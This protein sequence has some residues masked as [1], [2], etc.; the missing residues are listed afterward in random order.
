MFGF[1]KRKGGGGN[2][3]DP[4]SDLKTVSRW[5]ENLPAGDIY[6][7][8]EQVVQN[9]IQFN[10]AGLA[11]S[12]DRLQVLMHLDE[13]ARDMQYT[14]CQQYL[15]NPRMSKVIE[16]RLWTAIHAFYWEITRGYHAFLMDF[17]ANPGG[18]RIQQH[19]P[20]IAARALRG[21][22]DIFKWRYFRYERAEEK[23]WLR[24]HNIYRISEFDSFQNNRFKLYAQESTPSSC[25]EEYVRALLLSPLGSGSLTPR[26]IEMVDRWLSNWSTLTTL[27][28]SYNPEHHF[29]IVDTTHGQG[30]RRIRAQT[31]TEPSYRYLSTG[32]LLAHLDDTERALQGGAMPA[33]L[34]LGEDFRLPDGYDLIGY[35]RNEWAPTTERERRASPREPAD[36]RCEVVHD[37]GSICHRMQM[38]REIATG[39]HS[40][41]SLTPE[42]IL[43]IKLYGFVTERTKATIA[44]RMTGKGDQNIERW[45]MH[46]R[47]EF[48]IGITLKEEQSEWIRVGKLLAMRLDPASPWRIGIVRRITRQEENWRKIGVNLMADVPELASIENTWDRNTLT[49]SADGSSYG[50]DEAPAQVLVFPN[51]AEGPAM[52]LEASKYAHGRQYLLRHLD[53]VTL[54]K[55]DSVLEKG[56][57][58]LMATYLPL[59]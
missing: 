31:T 32:R 41:Q 54:I 27:D 40:S 21:F 8:Q 43:D 56:D 36:G 42:E 4:L 25:M 58:W 17:V 9:L 55:L 46:D 48:G 20:L 14:L 44:Q 23:L 51:R 39:V 30:L 24:V 28:T 47:S 12:K 19:I 6:T 49:Y 59:N 38:D 45:A 5:L 18:S 37:L 57:G 29:F 33:S 16:S 1:F 34:G 22:A 13:Q 2:S 53:I 11:M 26:Q 3:Q 35:V 15:R 52:I 7:A 50:G 10:H